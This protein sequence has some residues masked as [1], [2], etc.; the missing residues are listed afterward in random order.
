MCGWLCT[1]WGASVVK[2]QP[3]ARM[4]VHTY[5]HTH[6]HTY[7][8]TYTYKTDI[9]KVGGRWP[10]PNSELANKYTKLF[11]KFVNSINFEDL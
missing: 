11:Q 6:T 2:R 3:T 5:T 7:T 10:L 1:V 8:H 9:T 4:Y